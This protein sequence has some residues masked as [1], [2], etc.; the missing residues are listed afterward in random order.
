M[1]NSNNEVNIDE[2]TGG[3]FDEIFEPDLG[4]LGERVAGLGFT[5]V[6]R[7]FSNLLK[8]H[9]QIFRQKLTLTKVLETFLTKYLNHKLV[10]DKMVELHWKI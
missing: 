10:K 7:F 2:G 3:I 8:P 5:N 9:V 6:F 4:L 1:C